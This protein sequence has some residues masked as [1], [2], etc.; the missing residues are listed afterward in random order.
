MVKNSAS[1]QEIVIICTLLAM[2]GIIPSLQ[3]LQRQLR[4]YIARLCQQLENQG[5][6]YDEIDAL[7]RLICQIADTQL[8]YSL[9]GKGLNWQ[10]YK[11]SLCF[12]DTSTEQVFLTPHATAIQRSKCEGILLCASHLLAI[13]PVPLPGNPLPLLAKTQQALPPIQEGVILSDPPSSPVVSKIRWRPLLLQIML[14][15]LFLCL[16]W[17]SCQYYLTGTF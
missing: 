9:E 7:R 3:N 14:S 11:I 6:H 4:F 5:A 13:S 15:T 8:S 12:Y 17:S 1:A 16:M 10:D 2:D